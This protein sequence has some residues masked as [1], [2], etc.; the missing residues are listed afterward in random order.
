MALLVYGS[1]ERLVTPEP[2]RD[3]EAREMDHPVVQEIR[4]V[5]AGRGADSETVIA[6]LHVWRVGKAAHSWALSLVTH[7][8]SLTPNQVREWLPIHEEIAHSTIEI[9]RCPSV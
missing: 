6:D 1:I 8:D 9:H 2:I 4:E 7:D 5:I 3:Q